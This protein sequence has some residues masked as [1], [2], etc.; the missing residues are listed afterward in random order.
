MP[1]TYM[2]TSLG[3]G[4]AGPNT[5]DRPEQ[6]EWDSGC[7]LDGQNFNKICHFIKFETCVYT[8]FTQYAA[9][10]TIQF[11]IPL[12][13]PHPLSLINVILRSRPIPLRNL[14]SPL[15]ASD[16]I[17]STLNLQYPMKGIY[18]VA[19]QLDEQSSQKEGR[20]RLTASFS[21]SAALSGEGPNERTNG[22]RQTNHALN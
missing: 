7:I 5:A 16:H 22:T 15:Y 8:V 21:C 10:F 17:R 19:Q 1:V 6:P 12:L 2:N 13:E 14:K 18:T 20:V 9:I 11:H 3:P 4:H